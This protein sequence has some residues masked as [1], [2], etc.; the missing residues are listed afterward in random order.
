[1]AYYA[2]Y[3]LILY[4]TLPYK[5]RERDSYAGLEEA[6]NHVIMPLEKARWQKAA[7]GPQ[8]L[9]WLPPTANKKL[10]SSVDYSQ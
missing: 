10:G 3:C 4:K 6:N 8:H 2:Q 5:T 7:G 1:M 9:S